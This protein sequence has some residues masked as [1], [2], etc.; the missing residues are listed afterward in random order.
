VRRA[1]DRLALV[2]PFE[3][4]LWQQLGAD[5]RYVGHPSIVK[6][7]PER[8]A[9]RARLGFAPGAAA[10]ALVP[11]SRAQELRRH[12]EPMLDT[13]EQLGRGTSPIE[14]RLILA[15]AL[16][17][18]LKR[19]AAER[20]RRAGVAARE[21]PETAPLAAFDAA[22]VASGTATLECALHGVP[23]VIVYRTDRATE[24]VA[25]WALRVPHIGLPNLLLG[26]RVFPE[27]VQR[28]VC[29][30]RLAQSVQELL[31]AREALVAQCERVRE[32]LLEPLEDHP[33]LLPA[34]RVARWLRPWLD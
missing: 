27:L 21:A 6:R 30:P 3:Q 5:A 18:R 1:C 24:L 29:A 11:G 7:L 33:A 10:L 34:D 12:L 2:L 31:V 20:A 22:L 19:W 15:P 4:A 13:V 25:R 28:A 9:L 32:L 14:A 17:T 8:S 16:G 26:R 23:P